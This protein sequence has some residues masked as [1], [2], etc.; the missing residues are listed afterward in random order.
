MKSSILANVILTEDGQLYAEATGYPGA[1]S[2]I[3]I[4]RSNPSTILFINESNEARRMVLSYG[5]IVEDLGD[6]VEKESALEACTSK[7]EKGGQQAVTVVIPKPS[8]A[9][10]EPFTIT[11]PGVE[12]AKIDVFVP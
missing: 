12:G 5:K 11:V 9:S 10:D 6:G 2:A 7:V 8:S 4:Q 3:S 1:Q